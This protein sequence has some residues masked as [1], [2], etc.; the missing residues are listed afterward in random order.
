MIFCKLDQL[1]RYAGLS[2]HLDRAIRFLQEGGLEHLHMGRSEV[3][4]GAVFVNRFAYDTEADPITEAHL[5][6][7]DIHAVLEGEEQVGVADVSALREIERRE[8]EDYIGLTGEF[9]SMCTLRPGYVLIAFPED[10]HSP[11]RR[12]HGPCRVEKAVVKVLA[13]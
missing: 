9:Q 1:D 3:D 2:K 5:D 7:I 12:L 10:A 13:R 11:K 6:Y 4:G 8:E